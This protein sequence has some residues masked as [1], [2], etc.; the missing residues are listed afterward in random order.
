M[1]KKIILG[2][3][4]TLAFSVGVHAQEYKINKVGSDEQKSFDVL[5]NQKR[6][7][8]LLLVPGFML[9]QLF[10]TEKSLRDL[11]FMTNMEH[12]KVNVKSRIPKQKTCSS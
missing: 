9:I 3:G 1:R 11:P 6:Y 8:K 2:L 7:Q 12:L 5:L 10:P 4:I